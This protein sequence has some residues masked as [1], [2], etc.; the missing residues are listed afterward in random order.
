LNRPL[1]VSEASSV[2]ATGAITGSG[3]A[4][5]TFI[6]ND[7]EYSTLISSVASVEALIEQFQNIADIADK[8]AVSGTVAA[9]QSSVSKDPAA[10]QVEELLKVANSHPPVEIHP[11]FLRFEPHNNSFATS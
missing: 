5:A 2:V 11:L 1:H 4:A 3:A 6:E 8:A 7:K 9:S 10:R